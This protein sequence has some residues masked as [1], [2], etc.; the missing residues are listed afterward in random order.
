MFENVCARSKRTGAPA[1]VA[2]SL[3]FLLAVMSADAATVMDAWSTTKREFKDGNELLAT[4]CADDL[5]QLHASFQSTDGN[6]DAADMLGTD[7]DTFV[8]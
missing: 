2:P 7:M 4:E 5:A 6:G 8:S 1:D 3:L